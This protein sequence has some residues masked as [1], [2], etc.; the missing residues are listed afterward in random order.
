TFHLRESGPFTSGWARTGWLGIHPGDV[1]GRD[2]L[3]LQA[4]DLE[5]GMGNLKPF[6]QTLLD[7]VHDPRCLLD[8]LVP[9]DSEVAGEDDKTGCERPHME[10]MDA[11]DAGDRPDHPG[12]LVRPEV[13]RSAFKDDS[14]GISEEVRGDRADEGDD[15]NGDQRVHED[16]VRDGDYDRSR[17]DPD[18]PESVPV[19]VE[20]CPANV[21]VLLGR[22]T[23]QGNDH[24]ICREARQSDGEHRFPLYRQRLRDST[25]HGQGQRGRDRREKHRVHEGREDLDSMISERHLWRVRTLGDTKGRET[26]AQGNGIRPDVACITQEGKRTAPPAAERFHKGSTD[27]DSQSRGEPTLELQTRT[28]DVRG[29]SNQ[30]TPPKA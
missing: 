11:A 16:E 23:E 18:G 6:S 9:S 4:V 26:Q 7:S 8:G 15:E 2:D 27:G 29:H 14:S 25:I 20:E 28:V 12:D 1:R 17:N 30:P 24:E 21:D 10:V 19:R 5:G 22:A 3:V 13:D